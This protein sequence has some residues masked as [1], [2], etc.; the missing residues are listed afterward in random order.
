LIGHTKLQTGSARLSPFDIIENKAISLYPNPVNTGTVKIAF[1]QLEAGKYKIAVT[2]LQ[3]RL[4]ENKTVNILL[5]GQI[6][7]FT[8]KTKPVKGMYM[9]K[10]TD[11]GRQHIFSDKL[12]VE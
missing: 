12:I 4:I 7:N 6:E 8:L 3:G 11:S 9:I 2:D 10:I 1:G 5:K